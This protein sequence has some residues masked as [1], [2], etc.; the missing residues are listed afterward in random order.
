[1]LEWSD[2]SIGGSVRSLRPTGGF[3]T[4]R[5]RGLIWDCYPKGFLPP[6]TECAAESGIRPHMAV[7]KSSWRSIEPPDKKLGQI[8]FLDLCFSGVVILR[9]GLRGRGPVP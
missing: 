9:G 8:S 7:V 6:A 2:G 3:F 4:L 1:M 5:M